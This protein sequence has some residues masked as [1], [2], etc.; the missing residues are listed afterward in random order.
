MSNKQSSVEWLVE[1]LFESGV[2][3]TRFI[4]QIQQAKAMHKEEIEEAFANG[5]YDEYEYHI[6]NEPRKN[7][8]QYYSE[9]FGGNNEN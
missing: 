8:E 7:T 2:D 6:N 1:Q 3:T 5:V 9:T 4:P